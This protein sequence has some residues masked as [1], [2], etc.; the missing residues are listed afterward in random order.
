LFKRFNKLN[1]VCDFWFVVCGLWIVVCGLKFKVDFQIKQ[2]TNSLN[3]FDHFILAV[4]LKSRKKREFKM[5]K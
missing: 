4:K 2:S 1:N 5:R 3:L